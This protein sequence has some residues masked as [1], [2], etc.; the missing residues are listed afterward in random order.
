MTDY[1]VTAE[2]FVKKPLEIILSEAGAKELSII[3]DSLDLSPTGPI[4]QLNGIFGSE[5]DDL[6][7]VAEANYASRFPASASHAQLEGVCDITGVI[8]LAAAPSTV[9]IDLFL[10]AGVTVPAGSIVSIGENGARFETLAAVTNSEIYPVTITTEAQ[11]TETGPFAAYSGSINTIKTPVSGWSAKCALTGDLLG[12]YTL[13]ATNFAFRVDSLASSFIVPFSGGD[14]WDIDDVVD[15][16]NN[17]VNSV[18]I[19]AYNENGYLRVESNTDGEDS[20]LFVFG[21]PEGPFTEDID[22]RGLNKEDAVLGRNIETDP[23]LRLRRILWLN[24]LGAGTLEAIIAAVRRVSGVTEVTGFQNTSKMPDENGL[25]ANSYHIIV[26]GG[27]DLEIATII[28]LTAPAGIYSY[29]STL[30][31]VTDSQGTDQRIKFSR[32]VEV[33]IYIAATLSVDATLYPLDG[34]YQVSLALLAIGEALDSGDDVY[35]LRFRSACLTVKGVEDVLSFAID[36]VDPP[37]G[38]TNIVIPYS[39]LAVFH[40]DRIEIATV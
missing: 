26:V 11:C 9:D 2:G 25:P 32:P 14:P 18:Y 38:T 10:E 34:D 17:H 40:P 12:P 24:G 23:E 16:I 8:R 28:W 30:V 6:W 1:G 33:P 4:G 29:G 20:Y 31:M 39:S 35:E 13:D 19:T 37:T 15:E 22:I 21:R 36:V 5:V 27:D 7:A 3:D